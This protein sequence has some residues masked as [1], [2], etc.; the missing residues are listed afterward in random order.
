MEYKGKKIG[1]KRTTGAMRDI[2]KLCPGG[3]VKR[4]TEIFNEENL[5]AS[6][7][8]GVQFLCILNKWYEKALAFEDPGYTPDP[9]PEDF[10][11]M[12]DMDDFINLI[13]EAMAQFAE[14]DKTTVQAEPIKDKKNG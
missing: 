10:F 5:G 7:D 11:M 12:L 13:N 1:F 6:L 3:D 9:V 8:G 4:L 14:D 2:V